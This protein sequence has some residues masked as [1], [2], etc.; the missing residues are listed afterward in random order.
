MLTVLVEANRVDKADCDDIISQYA[1][2]V[3]DIPVP[4]KDVSMFTSL[5][6]S[7]MRADTLM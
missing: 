5:K 7:E 4:T 2:Y 6:P 3:E 1:R